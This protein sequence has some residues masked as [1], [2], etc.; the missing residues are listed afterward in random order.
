MFHSEEI[1]IHQLLNYQTYTKQVILDYQRY[2]DIR[3]QLME[4]FHQFQFQT[5]FPGANWLIDTCVSTK[6]KDLE[7]KI[8]CLESSTNIS[9][10]S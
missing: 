5:K 9:K 8:K 1:C 7:A 2:E 3:E 6:I 4:R 10:E